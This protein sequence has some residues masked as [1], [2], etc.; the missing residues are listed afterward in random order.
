MA[1]QAGSDPFASLPSR[2]SFDDLPSRDPFADVPDKEGIDLS[3]A[4]ETL[5]SIGRVYPILETAAEGITSGIALPASGIAGM[6]ALAAKAAGANVDPAAVVRSVGES[7]TYHPKTESGAQLSGAANY[8]FTKLG[9][10]SQ[11]A[12]GAVF[13]KTGSPALATAAEVAV[14]LGPFAALPLVRRSRQ[15]LESAEVSGHVSYV[16]PRTEQVERLFNLDASEIPDKA[17]NVNLEYI[18]SS[19]DA[20]AALAEVADM[21]RS[22]IDDARRGVQTNEQ[23]AKLAH[24][25]GMTPD[26]LM[27]RRKGRAFNAEEAFAARRMLVDSAEHLV[28]LANQ[29]KLGGKEDMAA[30]QKHFTRHVAIQEQVSGLTAEAG[31][32]LQQFQMIAGSDKARLRVLEDVIESSGGREKI[33]TIAKLIGNLDT[34]E[35]INRAARDMYKAKTSDMFL[36]A[37]INALL[38]GPQTHAVNTISN[39]LVAM[40]TVPEQLVAAGFGVL[41]KGDDKVFLSETPAKLYGMVEGTKEGLRMAAKTFYTGEPSDAVN[42]L[43]A[44]KYKAIPGLAGEIIRIPGRFLMSEDEFFKAI[45]Y[46][47]ELNA[48]AVR[49]AAKEGLSGSEFVNRIS[50][51]KNNPPEDI[52]LAATDASRYQTFTKPLGETG[53]SVQRFASS[54]PAAKVLLPF[55]RTPTNII[56]FAG[57]RT[58][59]ALFSQAVRDDIKKGGATRDIALARIAVGTS[60]SATVA[61][62]AAEGYIT[63]GGPTNPDARRTKYASGWQPYSIKV[64]DK[65]VSYSRVEPLGMLLGISADFAEISGH[66]SEEEADEL[67]GMLVASVSKNL[68]SKTWLQGISNLVEVFNDPDRYGENFLQSYAGTLIPTGVAQIARTQDPILRRAESVTE[69]LKSR[70]P[71]YSDEL[72]PRRNIWGDAI[73]LEGGVGPDIISPFY[74]STIKNHKATDELIRLGIDISMPPEK[75]GGVDLT[76]EQHDEFIVINGKNM[77]MALDA[78]VGSPAYDQLPDFVKE[79]GVR[80]ITS[81]IRQSSSQIILA[82]HPD[83]IRQ[84]ARQMSEKLQ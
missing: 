31:R 29:A 52:H 18:N 15:P 39:S 47:M 61:S 3:P 63:G 62:L 10:F 65:W 7:L 46:R 83:L 53:R 59:L 21:Y 67:A 20:K 82:R 1:T 78:F 49:Q 76:P 14:G 48:L 30:F 37:W 45:G 6:G 12:G 64:G 11:K 33:E 72:L 75:I 17:I 35:G 13:E 81:Q 27:K 58:P 9:E 70:I 8:P 28:K 22:S 73:A 4:I 51:I 71:G 24:D 60:V 77:R 43:E 55:I 79:R 25:L 26:D 38:S 32:A 19:D 16:E 5:R 80:S 54:H 69:K 42:K 2:S 50:E 66:L 68:V 84:Q 34:P 56:K 40:W 23:T 44:A 57:E 36:E 41:R 74:Q